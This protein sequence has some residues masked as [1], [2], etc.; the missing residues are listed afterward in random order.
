MGTPHGTAQAKGPSGVC[1]LRH[2]RYVPDRIIAHVLGQLMLNYCGCPTTLQ[3]WCPFASNHQ[4]HLTPPDASSHASGTLQCC[5]SVVHQ[6]SVHAFAASCMHSSLLLFPN[7]RCDRARFVPCI[8]HT[9]ACILNL[10][11]ILRALPWQD[12]CN[13]VL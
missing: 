4:P 6:T 12:V 13:P 5:N 2:L 9:A 10:N 1:V 3:H 7:A 8:T 11:S